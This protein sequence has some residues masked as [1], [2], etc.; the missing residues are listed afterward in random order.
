MIKF[1]AA[2]VVIVALA[3][4][5]AY[6]REE[7]ETRHEV[8]PPGSRLVVDAT[9]DVR[10]PRELAP[11]LTRGLVSSCLVE[12]QAKAE[13]LSFDWS[14]DEHFRFVARPSLDE[15]DQRQLRGCLEDLRV[16]RLLV[17]VD[18]MTTKDGAV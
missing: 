18:S 2:L 3:V 6:L 12:A 10:G 14:D 7:L 11:A 1:A 16:P 13:V 17:S 8:M 5:V 15:P 4:G 9:A